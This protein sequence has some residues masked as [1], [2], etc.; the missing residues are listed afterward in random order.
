MQADPSGDSSVTVLPEPPS[1]TTGKK[2]QHLQE[3]QDG[4][5]F[6][7]DDAT[8]G[9]SSLLVPLQAQGI[10]T[11]VIFCPSFRNTAIFY[12]DLAGQL[13]PDM[14]VY[15]FNWPEPT[16]DNPP[17]DTLPSIAE[18]FLRDLKTR[19]PQ[20]PYIVG[21][22]CFGSVIAIE[23]AKKLVES[24]EKVTL[25]VLI[26]PVRPS[27]GNQWQRWQLRRCHTIRFLRTHG[28]RFFI[29]SQYK[30]GVAMVQYLRSGTR[31][32]LEHQF[33]AAHHR[34]FYNY[35]A[36][37]CR[38]RALLVFSR[39]EQQEDETERSHHEDDRWREILPQNREILILP[40]CTHH[41]IL[42]LGADKI[43]ARIKAITGEIKK[44]A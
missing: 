12:Q 42:S 19:V 4:E 32:R 34:A 22:Y 38:H 30:R 36:R 25:L 26:D 18:E 15:S 14:A 11:T 29:R 9:N 17:A 41:N 6:T 1:G 21:G 43:A 27:T 20:G 16:A 10:G 3:H 35:R 44:A 23:M 37:A 8:T 39:A 33:Q 2:Y 24:G 7:S 40:D 5:E 28:I 31:E 13:A